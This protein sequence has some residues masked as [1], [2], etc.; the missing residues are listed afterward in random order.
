MANATMGFF[1]NVDPNLNKGDTHAGYLLLRY[2]AKYKTSFKK[3]KPFIC[4]SPEM[5]DNSSESNAS[6]WMN[7]SALVIH[8]TFIRLD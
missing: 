4:P 3:K 2:A 7:W 5:I 1:R 6:L 8:E